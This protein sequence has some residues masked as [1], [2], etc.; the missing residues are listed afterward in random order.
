MT[1]KDKF[2]K[3]LDF[4]EAL[5]KLLDET[6]AKRQDPVA[7]RKA[8]DDYHKLNGIIKTFEAELKTL[9]EDN[10]YLLNDLVIMKD[11]GASVPLIDEYRQTTLLLAEHIER[12][13]K[14]GSGEKELMGLLGSEVFVHG[15]SVV[16]VFHD[17]LAFPKRL[18]R[19]NLVL[20]Q[21]GPGSDNTSQEE[22]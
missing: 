13:L 16:F 2:Q 18:E 11:K 9:L 21:D 7:L 22:S 3:W 8:M 15:N 20:L 19:M 12:W 17:E 10:A 1:L 4:A 14:D 5:N 6:Y